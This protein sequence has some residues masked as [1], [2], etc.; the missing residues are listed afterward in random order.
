MGRAGE[1]IEG[2]RGGVHWGRN[3]LSLLS[4]MEARG[5]L[6]GETNGFSGNKKR[7]VLGFTCEDGSTFVAVNVEC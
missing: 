7:R 3:A 6:Y 5:S 4:M 2:V 1:E